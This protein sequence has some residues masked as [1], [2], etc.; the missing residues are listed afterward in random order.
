MSAS[1]PMSLKTFDPVIM[2]D[3]L[4]GHGGVEIS[5]RSYRLKSY[6]QC[7]TGRDAVDWLCKHYA[8]SRAQAQRVGELFIAKGWIEHVTQE[9]DFADGFLFYRVPE[10]NAQEARL[11]GNANLVALNQV[12]LNDLALKMR[13]PG[14]VP[15]R[16]HTRWLMKIP[17]VFSG[18]EATDWISTT[19]ALSR[20]EAVLLAKRLLAS[21]KIR[22][23]LDEEDFIDGAFFYRY[24]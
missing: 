21:N 14:G 5:D 18:R 13:Q 6:S 9:H 24:V 12:S 8:L 4:L 23:V 1:K 7:F 11:A 3:A 15:Q 22:H 19:Y 20:D 2:R 16:D 10:G 17:S